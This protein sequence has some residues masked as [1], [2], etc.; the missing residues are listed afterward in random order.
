[1]N[2]EI[3]NYDFHGN[4]VRILTD[5]DNAPWFIAKDI[6]NVL[7]IR[8]NSIRAILDED[9][10]GELANVNT[11]D[12]A[13]NGGRA[14][15]IVSESGFYK[16]VMR[17]RKTVAKEFQRWVT[18]D[19]LPSIRKHGAYM[20]TDTIREALADPDTLIMLATKLKEETEER[21]AAQERVRVLEPKARAYEDFCE[22]PDLLTVRDAAAQLTTAGLPIRECELRAWMLD[23]QWIY[24]KDRGYRPYAAHKDA[25]HV[26]LVPPKR[27]G[28]HRDGTPFPFDP[29]CKIT[30]RG[31]CLLYQ[32]IG[33]E[34]MR[35]QLQYTDTQYPFD[36]EV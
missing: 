5:Q 25:G 23:H 21:V 32:R 12:I 4:N 8:T 33:A 16:L 1:M 6:C 17:S 28:R 15:L 10:V 7:D 19:V 27:S 18:R 2:S 24:R 34:R 20:T 13:Q 29:T 9:E 22:A 26:R 14:P 11:I 31:L 36:E 30:R 35:D 3:V